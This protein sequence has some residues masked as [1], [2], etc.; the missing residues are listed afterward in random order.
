MD[1]VDVGVS[2]LKALNLSLGGSGVGQLHHTPATRASSPIFSGDGVKSDQYGVSP[3]QKYLYGLDGNLDCGLP[4]QPQLQQK[5]EPRH[6]P[7][8]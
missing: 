3:N 6:G 4:Q 8:Q 5:Y 2:Q 1:G 7:Q